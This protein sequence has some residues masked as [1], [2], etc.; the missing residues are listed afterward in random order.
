MLNTGMSSSV[1]KL[2]I[3]KE[4][5]NIKKKLDNLKIK[6]LLYNLYY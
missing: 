1:P 6:K 2:Y 3:I 5:E 4:V